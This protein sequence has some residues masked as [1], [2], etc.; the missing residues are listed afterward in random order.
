T[1]ALVGAWP[2]LRAALVR[3]MEANPPAAAAD[4]AG[5][6]GAVEG[7]TRAR[8]QGAQGDPA[9]GYRTLLT[10]PRQVG[11]S[12]D[13]DWLLADLAFKAGQWRDAIAIYEGMSRNPGRR[14]L[15]K[16]RLGQAYEAAGDTAQ[17]LDAYR[18]VLSRTVDSSPEFLLDDKAREAVARLGG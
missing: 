11:T 17:A 6:M 1:S 3:G 10:V 18:A 15:S 2:A 16:F 9:A 8:L 12:L 5:F 4:T 14:T 13:Q 7:V